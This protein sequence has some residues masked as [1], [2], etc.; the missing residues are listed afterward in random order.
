M[1]KPNTQIVRV[2]NSTKDT[3]EKMEELKKQL[4]TNLI[5]E[6]ETQIGIPFP[7]AI[8]CELFD[9]EVELLYTSEVTLQKFVDGAIDIVSAVLKDDMA[10]V[11]LSSLTLIKA[12]I[13]EL[14]GEHTVAIGTKGTSAII[15]SGGKKYLTAVYASSASCHAS[16]WGTQEDFYVGMYCMCVKNLSEEEHGSVNANFVITPAA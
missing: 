13:T 14:V 11:G 16:Q 5:S 3:E 1:P 2:V 15:H 10:Q 8:D 12:A 6:W 9:S 7:T 4:Q